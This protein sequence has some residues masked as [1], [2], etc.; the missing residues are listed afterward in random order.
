MLPFP[1]GGLAAQEGAALFVFFGA[2]ILKKIQNGHNTNHGFVADFT[3]SPFFIKICA[4]EKR[5]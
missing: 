1:L 4:L 2:Q 5:A 3:Q